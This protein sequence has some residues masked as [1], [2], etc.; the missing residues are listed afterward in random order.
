MKF[1]EEHP[2]YAGVA[3][4]ILLPGDK[5]RLDRGRP[6][7]AA[8]FVGC[9]HLLRLSDVAAVDYYAPNPTESTAEAKK[10]IYACASMIAAGKIIF[11]PRGAHVWHER[12]ASGAQPHGAIQPQSVQRLRLVAAPLPH[13]RHRLDLRLAIA[14]A[15]PV[16][17]QARARARLF[18]GPVAVRESVSEHR[19]IAGAC[20]RL[21]VQGIH[22]FETSHQR[23]ITQKNF[24]L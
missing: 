22:A 21:R 20:S 5:P 18:Q 17:L 3:Y 10:R 15:I 19:P 24:H 14:L 12:T 11:S 1:L 13:S 8:M 9:G 4:D 16:R 6:R 23:V 7:D 2:E